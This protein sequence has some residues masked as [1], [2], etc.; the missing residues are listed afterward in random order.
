MLFHVMRN[1]QKFG[2]ELL[3]DVVTRLGGYTPPNWAIALARDPR[4]VIRL[5][6]PD[7]SEGRLVVR[8]VERLDPRDV[9][10]VLQEMRDEWPVLVVA[11]FLS[12]ETRRRLRQAGASYADATGNMRIALDRPAVLIE[13]QGAQKNPWADI[14]PLSTLKGHAAGRVVRAMCDFKPPLGVRELALRAGLPLGTTARVIEFLDRE[15]LVQRSAKGRIE[16]ND[17][18]GTIRR[19]ACDYDFLKAN[20]HGLFLEPRGL[21]ILLEKLKSCDLTYA[22]TGSLAA[23]RLAPIAA[24]RLAMVYAEDAGSLAERLNLKRVEATGNVIII[25]AKGVAPFERTQQVDGVV[26][27]APGQVAV[28]LMNS[29]GRGPAEA[30]ALIGWM[31]EHKDVWRA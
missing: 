13:A 23:A 17:W 31:Q 3:Q 7:G 1:A 6:G 27:A 14:Q 21:P 22:V 16:G 10:E 29:P 26:Y 8:V 18:A 30:E 15:G 25:E 11:A 9:A 12:E 2:T 19:W 20:R 28:D 5:Q 4:D 24:P